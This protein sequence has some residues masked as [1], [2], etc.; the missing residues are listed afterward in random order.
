M[1]KNSTTKTVNSDDS[2]DNNKSNYRKTVAVCSRLQTRVDTE[3]S[4]AVHFPSLENSGTPPRQSRKFRRNAISIWDP[5]GP[6]ILLAKPKG[7]DEFHLHGFQPKD[8]EDTLM[9]VTLKNIRED[10]SSHSLCL[11]R[12]PNSMSSVDVPHLYDYRINCGYSEL[13]A[14]STPNYNS[15]TRLFLR[16]ARHTSRYALTYHQQEKKG[17]WTQNV[18]CWMQESLNVA[19]EKE[20]LGEGNDRKLASRTA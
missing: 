13:T 3:T 15:G 18:T 9:K 14:N 19:E 2:K 4:T 16:Y 11:Q 17:Y 7:E 6:A 10:K 20:A 12:C 5:C 8:E 1:M